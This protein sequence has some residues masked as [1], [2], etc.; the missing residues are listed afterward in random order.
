MGFIDNI[1]RTISQ[2]IDRAKFEADKFQKVTR[3]QGEIAELR[4]QIDS[5][6]LELS[7]R[8]IALYKAGQITSTTLGEIIK[9][10]EGLQGS[11]TVKE[12]ELK[13]IQAE[14]FVEPAPPLNTSTQAQQVPIS[15]EPTPPPTPTAPMP[16]QPSTG[17][18]TC[19]NCHFQMP[20][21][22]VF[23]PNCGTRVGA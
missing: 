3:V 18:K 14:V 2:G 17:T 1:S 20:G 11:I 15:Y 10:I 21:S 9:V 16:R 7:D 5:R 19:P 13:T 6:R 22:A 23:C 12:E 4:K 8:A